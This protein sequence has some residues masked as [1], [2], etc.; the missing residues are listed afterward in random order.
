MGFVESI[1]VE[2]KPSLSLGA[3]LYLSEEASESDRVAIVCHGFTAYRRYMFLPFIGEALATN[4]IP[5]LLIDFSRVGVDSETGEFSDLEGFSRNTFENARIELVECI[6]A[7]CSKNALA[8]F[9]LTP[10]QV[11]LMGHSHGGVSVLGAAADS[12]VSQY[13]S[14]VSVWSTPSDIFPS[15]F[16]ATDEQIAFWR[17]NGEI[18]YP[19]ERLGIEVPLKLEVLEDMESDPTRVEKFV[20]KISCPLQIIHG[21]NDERIPLDCGKNLS[22][23]ATESELLV[24][25]GADHVFNVKFP[26]SEPTP[27]VKEA[28]K[29][30]VDFLTRV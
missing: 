19:V 21:E 4:G 25:S 14:S 5:A 9:G 24:I 26:K 28:T 15:R 16:G 2:I 10:S 30:L 22:G 20:R 8:S 1:E 29:K 6:E 11:V 3:D 27:E 17:E 7:I 18:P 12:S 13:V 23:W